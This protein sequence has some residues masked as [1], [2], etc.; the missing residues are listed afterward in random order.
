M[1]PNEISLEDARQD[2]LNIENVHSSLAGLP[3]TARWYIDIRDWESNGKNLPLL[4]FLRPD[5]QKAVTR[6]YH[7]PDKRMSLASHLLKYL[8]I[9]HAC[10]IPWKHIILRRTEMPEN[11]PYYKSSSDTQVEFNVTH[12]AGLTIL[13]G[14]IA[15]SPEQMQNY[16]IGR[17]LPAQPRLGIDVTCVNE[18]RRKI[19]KTMPEYLEHV[20]IFVDVFSDRE[21]E[22]MRN[23]AAALNQARALGLAKAFDGSNTQETIVRFGIRLFYSYWALKEAYLKMTGDALLA[24]WLRTLEF[25]NVIP[26]DPV[27][28]L[29]APKPYVSQPP[30]FIPQSPKNWGPPFAGVKITKAGKSL[31][32]VRLQLVAFESDYIV[33]VA[34]RGLPVGVFSDMKC[35]EG[36]HH[37]PAQITLLSGDTREECCIPLSTKKVIGD[38]DPWNIPSVIT[39]PWLPMQ[40]VDVDNDIRACAEG[41]CVHPENQKAVFSG[42]IIRDSVYM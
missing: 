17:D 9:H 31:D 19:I 39:D 7:A 32:D 24:P 18:N 13:A 42:V 28:P 14:T 6:Y 3:T 22:I 29:Q 20:S 4:E 33:A 38:M 35:N 11:R 26:P 10:G 27:D 2:N 40:E 23:P 1:L 15:P 5:E 21:L 8:F 12:Q 34:G 41:R 30:K 37:L 25:S 16:S 36:L